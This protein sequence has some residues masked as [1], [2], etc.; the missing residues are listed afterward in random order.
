MVEVGNFRTFFRERLGWHE[1]ASDE[2]R[3]RSIKL[4]ACSG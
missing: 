1:T 4:R 3:T 2:K